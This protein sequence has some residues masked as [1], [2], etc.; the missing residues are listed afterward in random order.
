MKP[1]LDDAQL[2]ALLRADAQLRPADDGFST[3]L[4]AALPPQ[5][6][7]SA[8]PRRAPA[9]RW[10]PGLQAL[11]QGALV[12]FLLALWPDLAAAVAQGNGAAVEAVLLSVA[13]LG[14]LSWW[15][16]PQARNALWR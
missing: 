5:L 8:Q 15:T 11:A 4:L 3:R 13:L 1:E 2:D 6:S 9:R 10:L 7:A 16:L 12:A 14:L